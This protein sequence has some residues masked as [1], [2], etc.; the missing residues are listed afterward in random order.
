MADSN[1]R[2]ENGKFRFEKLEIWQQSVRI[3]QSIYGLTKT[4]PK[5]KLY[6]ITSQLHRAVIS[7]S[8]N[9]AEGSGGRSSADFKRFLDISIGSALE[10]VSLMIVSE[11]LGYLTEA[12]T[13][14]VKL[15]LQILI[16]RIYAFK[17]TF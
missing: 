15:E 11:K 5:D 3:I 16:K 10:T 7:I 6:G 9:I 2:G 17:K 14:S 4:F 13:T 1:W 8:S 12:E